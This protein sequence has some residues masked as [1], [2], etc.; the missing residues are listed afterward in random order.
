MQKETTWEETGEAEDMWETELC[1]F[2]GIS[3]AAIT[4][5]KKSKY[6]K[7]TLHLYVFK[8]MCNSSWIWSC[9][10]GK[11]ALKNA[12][13]CV[14]E[15]MCVLS[16]QKLLH[17][18]IT[19]DF[20]HVP[21]QSIHPT[22]ASRYWPSAQPPPIG[23][24]TLTLKHTHKGT[25]TNDFIIFFLSLWLDLYEK[26][27]YEETLIK[28]MGDCKRAAVA[29]ANYTCVNDVGYFMCVLFWYLYI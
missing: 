3:A 22:K 8:F 14:C 27:I 28:K 11:V 6:Q 13:A 18:L 29:L 23:L 19:S 7:H 4:F 17:L 25:K 5:M 9:N 2:K 16:P 10:L 21:R 24:I 26:F 20:W 15:C 1:G 12:P